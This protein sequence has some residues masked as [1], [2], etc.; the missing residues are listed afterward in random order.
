LNLII[1]LAL[2]E[3]AFLNDTRRDRAE[4][5]SEDT[6]SEELGLDLL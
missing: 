3:I 2:Q 4:D 5:K 6:S 1:H